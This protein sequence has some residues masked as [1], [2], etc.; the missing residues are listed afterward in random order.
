LRER[1]GVALYGEGD[2]DLAEI[3]LDRC[4]RAGFRL[5][6]GESCTGGLVGGRLTAIPGSSDVFV[7]GV[8]AYGDE[9][10]V[11]LLGISRELLTEHGAVSEAVAKH[12]AAG[13]RSLMRADV[14]LGVTGIAGP[15]GGTAEKPVGTVW[16]AVDID[17]DV[18]S[19]GLRLW[20]D[21]EEI[22]RR[23]A[24]AVLDLA[25]RTLLTRPSEQ[26]S[27]VPAIAN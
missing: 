27:I 2:T 23:S 14:G 17:G 4:R 12:M 24:Q 18:R 11:Q 16:I 22:R 6:V 10:K 20:G 8:V 1:I 9:V 3:V 21:R 7:G 26:P 5:A 13:A 19:A 15:D 25:R